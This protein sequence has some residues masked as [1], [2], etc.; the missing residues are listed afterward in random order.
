VKLVVWEGHPAVPSGNR[1]FAVLHA[2]TPGSQRLFEKSLS[3]TT[4][5]IIQLSLYN[6]YK[7]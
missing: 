4:D 3:E 5:I 7:L 2:R 1:A 6:Y